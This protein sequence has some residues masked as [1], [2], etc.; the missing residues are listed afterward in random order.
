MSRSTWGWGRDRMGTALLAEARTRLHAYFDG[1]LSRFDLPLAPRWH[2]VPAARSGGAPQHSLWRDAELCRDRPHRGRQ[3]TLGRAGEWQQ[4]NSDLHPLSPRCRQRRSRRL[5]GRRRARYQALPAGPR[6]HTE[7]RVTRPPGGAP[8]ETENTMSSKAIRIHAYGGPE[9]MQ[10]EDVPTPSR[11]P[12]RRWCITR[13]S[14]STTSTSIS[15]PGC[16]NRRPCP[17]TLGMEG[18]GTVKAVGPEVADVK[19]GRPG[20]GYAGAGIGAYATDRVIAAD[21]LVK[22]PRQRSTSRPPPP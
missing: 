10:W 12:A 4:P 14:A 8:T 6:G 21:K 19:V 11:G 9:V 22:L 17:V 20:G 7:Q 13:R 2:A 18:A 3:R 5:L 15:A 1:D 16:T